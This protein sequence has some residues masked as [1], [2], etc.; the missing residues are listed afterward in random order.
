MSKVSTRLCSAPRLQSW[1]IS[2]SLQET[3]ESRRRG[4][5][6]ILFGVWN[7][8]LRACFWITDTKTGYVLPSVRHQRFLFWWGKSRAFSSFSYPLFL[9]DVSERELFGSDGL[10]GALFFGHYLLRVSIK[11]ELIMLPSTYNHL[12]LV[13]WSGK[14]PLPRG[15]TQGVPMHYGKG[16]IAEWL[17]AG[18]CHQVNLGLS[19]GSTTS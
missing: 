12:P 15:F 19:S 9:K 14:T 6:R 2:C 17:R 13:D 11:V 4:E 7:S 8:Q 18:L 10:F 1:L 3:R 16:S 5:C